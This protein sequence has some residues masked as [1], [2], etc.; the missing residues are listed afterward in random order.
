MAHPQLSCR[1]VLCVS[2]CQCVLLWCGVVLLL[3]QLLTEV[4]L[5]STRRQ[6]SQEAHELQQLGPLL[7]PPSAT[8][9]HRACGSA[10][11]VCVDVLV[12]LWAVLLLLAYACL[13]LGLPNLYHTYTAQHHTTAEHLAAGSIEL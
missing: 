9:Q 3:L 11:A 4:S 13:L 7:P 2:V 8:E 6:D 10:W 1:A 12:V 5:L